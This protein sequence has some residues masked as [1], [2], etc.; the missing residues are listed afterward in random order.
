MQ[1]GDVIADR[2]EI[3]RMAGAGGMGAVY[4][5]LDRTSGNVVALK[6]LLT[7]DEENTKRFHRETGLLYE[8]NH[9]RIVR[10][11]AHGHTPGGELYLVMEWLDGESLGARLK[12]ETL[13]VQDSITVCTR[14]AEGVA[15]AHGRGIVHR[16]IKPANLY[17]VGRDFNRLKLLDFG[18]GRIAAAGRELTRT[19]AMLGTP[20][21]MAP[22]QARGD[23]E[24]DARSDV[25]AL[26]CVLFRCITGRTVFQADD[27]LALL[28]KLV[29]EDA[30]RLRHLHPGV[31]ADLD[32]LV[33]R[34]LAR[35]PDGRPVDGGAVLE[36]L[37]RIGTVPELMA[38]SLTS[39]PSLLAPSLTDAERR[40]MCVVLAR[41]S[42]ST[43]DEDATLVPGQLDRR[44]SA[45]RSAV[46]PLGGELSLLG[47]GTLLVTVTPGPP[48]EQAARAARCALLLRAELGRAPVALSAGRGVRTS[49]G[50]PFG[51]AVDRA[52][53]LLG[54]APTDAVRVNPVAAALLAEHFDV[55]RDPSG[56]LLRPGAV[57][58]DRVVTLL[59]RSTP[60]VGR[61]R[62]LKSLEATFE[63]AVSEPVARAVLVTGRTGM[64]KSRLRYEFLRR[65]DARGTVTDPEGEE[66]GFVVWMARGDPMSQGASFG[67]IAALVRHAVGVRT[68]DP[69]S[70]GRSKILSRLTDRVPAAE[71]MRMAEFLGELIGTPFDAAGSV[72]LGAARAD[73][74]LMGDQIRRAWE[75]WLAAE[76]EAG[77][78]LL[79]LEDLHYGD[80]PSVQLLDSTLRNLGDRPLMVLALARP[81]VHELF[82]RMWS[83]RDVQEIR[84]SPLTRKACL[85][86][87]REM[88]GPDV[89]PEV[90]NRVIEQAGGNAFF[91]EELIRA[92]C[93]GR[94]QA[95]PETVLAMVQ[96]RLDGLGPEMRRVLRAAAVFGQV[97]WLAG[98][99]ALLGEDAPKD[100]L[101]HWVDDLVAKELVLRRG[102]GRFPD[103]EEFLFRNALAC[104]AAYGML[105]DQD[106]ILGHRLARQWLERVGEREPVVLGEHAER[107]GERAEAA[108]LYGRA[109]EQ[110]LEGN[111]LG[112]VLGHAERAV[113]CGAEHAELGSVR[114]LQAIAHRWR[115]EFELMLRVGLEARELLPRGGARWCNA[116][117]EVGVACRALGQLER[118]GRVAAELHDVTPAPEAVVPW[119]K[120]VARV[121]M[122]LFL[123]GQPELGDGVL[124][125]VLRVTNLDELGRRDPTAVAAMHQARA[126]QALYAGDP[127]GYLHHSAAAGAFLEQAG[128][129]RG[130][131]NAR[132]HLGFAY[133]EVGAYAD[134][135]KALRQAL[136]AA[137]RMGLH[138]V[139][140][141]AKNNLGLVLARLGRLD[142]AQAVELEAVRDSAAQGV[143]RMEGGSRHYL[144]LIL[145]LRGK[146]DEAEREAR[147]AAEL[148]GISPALRAH[149]LATLGQILLCRDQAPAAL[150]AAQAAMQVLE[151][152]GAIEE[153]EAAVR[154]TYARALG[155]NG[156][157]P[158]ADRALE[159]ARGRLLERA[160]KIRDAAWRQSFLERVPENVSTF[161]PLGDE[162]PER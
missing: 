25:Y 111:D 103:Q 79:V 90:E 135:E 129:L 62:E 19:G 127:S 74:M 118:L 131:C 10:Y 101:V 56:L 96:T 75:D 158:E 11:I 2:F 38:P 85:E 140:A 139:V 137:E 121:A 95:L 14:A 61:N 150:E 152:L 157:G 92:V 55:T 50:L 66:R 53:E 88:L 134:A 142:E 3:E 84:L 9:P 64:G 8:L 106:R 102:R 52:V 136:A 7:S 128:D 159:E 87:V 115:G 113:G 144:A 156:R 48:A 73:P 27:M 33:A 70:L 1:P 91:L 99:G 29:L 149:A 133:K 24:I 122:Q 18:L 22:E 138:V 147:A 17:L 160:G 67:M 69:A 132:V 100:D 155:R 151:S 65:L 77:P 58:G 60:T 21:Y 23:K 68:G 57:V 45:L 109:A 93:E 32:D 54:L 105:T 124:A 28:A 13:S 26:G 143:R 154:L 117:A 89:S 72:Q 40:V 31:P 153:G 41:T 71:R 104:E 145:E 34:L 146:L 78:V 82:P 15:Y 43:S 98:L 114:L 37:R 6:T 141:T 148:L 123:C 16:D 44:V 108:V 125:Q 47:D 49:S 110:A 76:C 126:F 46:T 161:A 30:P 81:E 59:G 107:G 116:M 42:Q 39:S 97:F 5:S 80:L 36:E 86:L 112:L 4:R 130:A 20:G 120:A 63:E 83:E 12:R 119:A 51:E 162:G 94:D 35:H